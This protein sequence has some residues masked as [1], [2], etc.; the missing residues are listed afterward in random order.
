MGSIPTGPTRAEDQR[1]SV[2]GLLALWPPLGDGPVIGFRADTDGLPIAEQTGLDYSSEATGTL[3]DGG[4][5]P[6]M[7]GCGHDTH[8]TAA[9]ALA[10]LLTERR[11]LWQG[12]LVLIFQP[13]ELR[14]TLARMRCLRRRWGW[15]P[16][17]TAGS[18]TPLAFRVSS[19]PLVRSIRNCSTTA[20]HRPGTTHR[21]LRRTH[22]PPSSEE[23][24]LRFP[25]C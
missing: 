13:G 25:E 4:T 19:G 18:A 23:Q 21:S 14:R 12:T 24:G 1:H 15:V 2:S 9:L 16:K 7:H 3:P 5:A 17:M 10:S 8:I 11:D 6:V 20:Q 22:A